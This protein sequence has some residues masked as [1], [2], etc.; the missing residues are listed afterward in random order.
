MIN[1]SQNIICLVE[2][3]TE[4]LPNLSLESYRYTNLLGDLEL[5]YLYK[6]FINYTK[7]RERGSQSDNIQNDV[8]I[9][10]DNKKEYD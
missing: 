7:E 3:R 9:K 2:I 5:V 8:N 6:D 1:V 10:S 4:L